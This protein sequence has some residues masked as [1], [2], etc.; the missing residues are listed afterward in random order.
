[1]TPFA[2]FIEMDDNP[3]LAAAMLFILRNDQGRYPIGH[4]SSSSKWY[5]DP[6]EVVDCCKSIRR[7]SIKWPYSLMRHC[8]TI[9]HIASLFGADIKGVRE[10]IPNARALM[11]LD[12]L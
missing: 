1:M 9:K 7:P 6:I 12:Q 5:P 2:K 11:A 10:C 4:F 3:E 8:Y